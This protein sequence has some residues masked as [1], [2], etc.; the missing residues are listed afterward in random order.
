MNQRTFLGL[1]HNPFT[2]PKQGF[3]GGADRRTHLDHLRHLSQWSRRVLVVTGP[4]GIGKSSLF[5]ELSNN[6]EPHTKGA[7]LSG[8]VVTS[9]RDVLVGLVQGFGVAVPQG[10][11][12]DD[13]ARAVE[14]H[15]AEQDDAE[16]VCMVIVDDAHALDA[17]AIRRLMN[18]VSMSALRLVLFGEAEVIGDVTPA[19]KD[20]DL[21]WFEIRLTGFPK[22]DVRDYLEWRFAQAQYRGRLPFTDEQVESIASRS[23]GSPSQIDSLAA[24]LL[25]DLES[26]D[27]RKSQGGFPT[28]HLALAGLLVVLVVLVYLFVQGEVLPSEDKPAVAEVPTET[29]PNAAA[30]APDTSE[31]S[32]SDGDSG[33]A[34]ESGPS[35]VDLGFA[36]TSEYRSDRPVAPADIRPNRGAV[37]VADIVMDSGAPAATESRRDEA[38]DPG[39]RAVSTQ[40]AAVTPESA[41]QE[42]A[43]GPAAEE[44]AETT[45]PVA[46]QADSF[47]NAAW[48]LAQGDDQF[49]LQLL[50]LSTRE[51]AV[52]FMNRQPDPSKFALYSITREGKRLYVVTYGLYPNQYSAQRTAQRLG[53]ELGE[54]N[55]WVRSLRIVKETVRSHPQGG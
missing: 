49:I 4:F 30:S 32:D 22:A 46:T 18:L 36:A 43:P 13:L 37:S 11:S 50:T 33:E 5:K 10:A 51:R 20:E 26:G 31:R 53:G 25:A 27:I 40:A 54:I 52:D 47:Q 17:A 42:P 19:S 34:A 55:A 12:A 24:S 21:E 2:S 45:E 6:L 28:T 9:E 35:N 38:P 3:F 8:A 44:P 39:E 1:S 15:V 48:L 7:R 29:V 14:A 41:T 16:R 23:G